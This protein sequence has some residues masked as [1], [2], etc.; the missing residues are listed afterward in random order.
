M[1]INF[2]YV[3]MYVCSKINNK[4]DKTKQ[5]NKTY[6]DN[7]ELDEALANG[8]V[9]PARLTPNKISKIYKTL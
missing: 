8:L 6:K 4:V 3:C 2:V 5:Q 9:V 7:V 1:F